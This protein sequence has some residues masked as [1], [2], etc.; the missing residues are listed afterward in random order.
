MRY[1]HLTINDRNK[2]EI[3]SKESYSS[4][5]IA[6][7]LGFHLLIISRKLWRCD[8]EYEAVYAQKNKIEK[9]SSKGRKPKVDDKIIKFISEKLD[10]KWSPEQIANTVYKDIVWFKTMYNWIYSGIIDFDISKL[11]R[12]EKSRKD[13]ETR[14]RF[15]IGKSINKRPKEVKKTILLVTG[16]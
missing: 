9:S 14:G 15:N 8:N 2:I 12:N 13:K 7:I 4:R 3:L 6:K 1:K 10:K 5:R 11:R 16:N